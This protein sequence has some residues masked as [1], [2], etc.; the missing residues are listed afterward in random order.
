MDNL[1]EF[2]IAGV[3]F[4]ESKRVQHF[5]S[6]DMKLSM[7]PEPENKYDSNAIAL[8]F[9]IDPNVEATIVEDAMIGYVPAKLSAAMAASLEIYDDLECVLTEVNLDNKPWEKFKV[10]IRHIQKEEKDG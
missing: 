8:R 10:V 5:M 3:Q 4:H 6:V 9:E 2:Y 1:V 7:T